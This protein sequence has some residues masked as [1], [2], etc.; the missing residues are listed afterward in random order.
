MT[1]QRG[2][3]GPPI[4]MDRPAGQP[5]DLPKEGN[6]RVVELPQGMPRHDQPRQQISTP[7]SSQQ[8]AQPAPPAPP[9]ASRTAKPEAEPSTVSPVSSDEAEGPAP[10]GSIAP[11]R[12]VLAAG[13]GGGGIGV[14]LS[15]ILAYYLPEMPTEVAVAYSGLLVAVLSFLAGYLVPP[16]R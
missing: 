13:A 6:T 10:V 5:A 4:T 15:V 8:K 3:T 7:N 16:E 1:E 14:P 12:K 2:T 9:E 11:T